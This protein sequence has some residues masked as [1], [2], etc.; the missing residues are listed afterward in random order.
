MFADKA[1]LRQI[2]AGQTE[3][4]GLV[5]ATAAR[6]QAMVAEDLRAAGIRPDDNDASCAIIAARE[7]H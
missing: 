5:P 2:M 6:T 3:M 4:M 1:E 7:Q